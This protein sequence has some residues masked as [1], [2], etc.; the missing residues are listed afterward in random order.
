MVLTACGV[1][2]RYNEDHAIGALQRVR[3]AEEQFRLK[4]GR[5]GSREDLSAS[6]WG[7]PVA[8]QNGYDFKFGATSD[9]YF[10]IATPIQYKEQSL[11]LYLDQSGIIR[12]MFKNGGEANMNDPELRGPDINPT[13]S[14]SP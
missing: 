12:G 5:Y 6:N 8:K 14:P 11:S 1:L 13:P 4:N 7:I 10:V 9:S 2:P 3:D